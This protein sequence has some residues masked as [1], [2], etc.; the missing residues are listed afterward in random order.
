MAT[1]HQEVVRP[2][3]VADVP[4]EITIPATLALE[5]AAMLNAIAD[6]FCV[7]AGDTGESPVDDVIYDVKFE[8]EVLQRLRV[9]VDAE[10]DPDEDHPAYVA[11]QRHAV[12]FQASL[13]EAIAT[14]PRQRLVPELMPRVRTTRWE[15]AARART[16]RER[17]EAVIDEDE[18]GAA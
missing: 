6:A 15:I 11:M 5:A 18:D 16:L 17:L 2:T 1:A 7:L 13:L 10:D 3:A 14:D 12:T 4:F 8:R 9:V